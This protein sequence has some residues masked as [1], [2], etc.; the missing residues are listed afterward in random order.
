[1]NQSRRESVAQFGR[2]AA[3]NRRCRACRDKQRKMHLVILVHDASGSPDDFDLLVS[4]LAS[5]SS[6]R[7][8][9]HLHLL[10]SDSTNPEQ[11]LADEIAAM[12]STSGGSSR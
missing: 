8:S 7:V 9:V 4:Q 11:A 5:T 12:T 2:D 10:Q 3:D 6:R 1:M